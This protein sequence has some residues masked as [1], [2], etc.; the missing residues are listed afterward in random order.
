MRIRRL[1]EDSLM[2]RSLV[3]LA[4]VVI[5]YQRWLVYPQVA[6]F[7]VCVLYTK[8]NLKFDM[9]R[10]NLVGANQ[11]Y[12][13][14]FMQFK[15]EFPMQ[16][17]LAVVVESENPE[18]NRQ[19]VERLGTKLETER[20]VVELRPGLKVETNLFRDVF[21]K[22]DLKMLGSKALLFIGEDD[23]QEL[24]KRLSEY[25]PFIEQ[26]A[27]TTNLDSLFAMINK[28]FRT[29]KPEKSAET[30]AMVNALPVLQRIIEQATDSLRRPGTPPSPGVTALFNP[31]QNAERKVYI[32]FADG[33]IYL[34]TAHAPTENLNRKALQ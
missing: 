8:A 26:F 11:K 9:G 25:R 13:Q 5:R 32:T 30:D 23:L 10:G 1:T 34:L 14:N 6:L 16:D 22:G 28:Q 3:W 21:Y 29:A 33:R 4:G 18:K 2:A 17:D 19:F 24:K 12:H 20:V 15:K 31:G 27:H 7:V